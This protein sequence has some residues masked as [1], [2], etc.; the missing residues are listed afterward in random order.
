MSQMNADHRYLRKLRFSIN[1]QLAH[2]TGLP[3]R[4]GDAPVDAE[5]AYIVAKFCSKRERHSA[6]SEQFR[7]TGAM[8]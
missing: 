1:S 3:D 4:W 5:T 8:A 2:E 6:Q 7:Q